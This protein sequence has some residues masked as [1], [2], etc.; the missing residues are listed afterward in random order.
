MALIIILVLLAVGIILLIRKGIR[1]AYPMPKTFEDIN[2]GRKTD[3]EMMFKRIQERKSED[4][5]SPDNVGAGDM[6][7]RIDRNIAFDNYND[8]DDVDLS[9]MSHIS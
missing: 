9:F 3:K 7:N 1:D 2:L 4:E 5:Y 8:R 6:R